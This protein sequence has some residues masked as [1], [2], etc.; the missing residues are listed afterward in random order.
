MC[1]LFWQLGQVFHPGPAVTSF[2]SIPGSFPITSC[3]DAAG[4]NANDSAAAPAIANSVYR[5]LTPDDD[6]KYCEPTIYELVPV[7]HRLWASTRE[8]PGKHRDQGARSL[9]KPTA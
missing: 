8:R 3:A 2:T 6:S 5:M 9:T 7:S 1:P 4:A